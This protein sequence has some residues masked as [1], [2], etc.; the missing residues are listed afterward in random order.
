MRACGRAHSLPRH[1]ERPSTGL[2][3]GPDGG[4]LAYVH[5]LRDRQLAL[6]GRTVF[7]LDWYP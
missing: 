3:K 1:L 5:A 6:D 2:V 4:L 7:D